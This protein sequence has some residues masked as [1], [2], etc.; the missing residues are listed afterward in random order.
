VT[1]QPGQT[2]AGPV[3]LVTGASQ[4][5]G[6]AIAE[7]F[8]AC[9]PGVRLALV[10]RNRDRLVATAER[11]RR[12]GA[13]SVKT[14]SAEL[15]EPLEVER[16]AE[17]A[18]SAFGEIDVLVNNA[19][20][21][22]GGAVH[23]MPVAEFALSLQENLVSMFAVTRAFLPGMLR[24]GSGDIFFISSTSGLQGLANNAAYCAAKHG[25]VGLSRALRAEVAARG[26]RVCCVYPGPTETPT[27]DGT[28]VDVK[29]LM[30]ATD[31]AEVVVNAHRL[32]GRSMME[33]VVLR[34]PMC[35]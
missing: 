6:A 10:A 17:A 8:A 18:R 12:A 27:W 35:A 5:I 24:R 2:E 11:C 22:R 19:G 13:A 14:F 21:W 31:V 20:H 3:V 16:M 9:I 15:T 23:E 33:D 28:D 25:V 1:A 4:G 30:S 29:T 34:P 7:R 32:S 26:I